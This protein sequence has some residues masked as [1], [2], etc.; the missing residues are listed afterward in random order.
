MIIVFTELSFALWNGFSG[1][2]Y[3]VDWF[4][5]L[6]NAF[7]TSWPCLFTFSLEK[8]VNLL[9]A[10]KFPQLFECGNKNYYFNMKFFWT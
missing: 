1:Q 7:W 5:T 3:F 8:G 10:K 4:S 6:Y 9:I 2:I